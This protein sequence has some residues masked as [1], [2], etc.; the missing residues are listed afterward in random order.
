[1]L[2]HWLKKS[3]HFFVQ[4]EVKPKLAVTRTLAF[5]RISRQLHAITSSFNCIACVPCD[6]LEGLL[7]FYDSQLKGA[8]YME[9]YN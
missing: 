4:S 6:W 2:Q 9:T 3:F 5:S 1:M 7:W 8:L